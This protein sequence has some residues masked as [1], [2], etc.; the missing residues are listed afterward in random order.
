M[1]RLFINGLAASAGGGLAYLWNVFAPL[2]RR[3]DS[4]TMVLLNTA[5]CSEFGDLPNISFVEKPESSGTSGAFQRFV[6]EQTALP[7]LIRRSGAQILISTGNFVLWNSPIPQI[8]LSQNS[9]YTSVDFLR[10]L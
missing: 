9:L 10:D 7:K 1:I 8:L 5:V 3:V 2:E 4:E 6:L